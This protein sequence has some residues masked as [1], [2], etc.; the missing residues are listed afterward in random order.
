MEID[1]HAPL[2]APARDLWVCFP[3]LLAMFVLMVACLP[4][5]AATVTLQ[6]IYDNL[7]NPLVQAL[8]EGIT[9]AIAGWVTWLV[10]RYAPSLVEG[11]LEKKAATDLNTALANGVV[12]AMHQLEAIETPHTDIEV[13]GKITA[14]AAQYAIDHAP[15]AVSRF[16][17]DPAQL[18]IKALAFVPTAPTTTDTTGAAPTV[19]PVQVTPLPPPT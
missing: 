15:G 1:N 5:A 2:R 19:A 16:G 10:Q 7:I 17:L 11:W 13:K 6:P 9:L 12:I 14:W 4:A 18:A 3:I 8:L